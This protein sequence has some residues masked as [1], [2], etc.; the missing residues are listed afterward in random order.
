MTFEDFRKWMAPDDVMREIGVITLVYAR[1][2]ELLTLVTTGL[3]CPRNEDK[4]RAEIAQKGVTAKLRLFKDA[5]QSYCNITEKD[6][7][8][9]HSVT[10]KAKLAIQ[11]RDDLVHGYPVYEV[12]DAHGTNGWLSK[13]P[14]VANSH[15]LT[16]GEVFLTAEQLFDAYMELNEVAGLVWTT[17]RKPG[18]DAKAGQS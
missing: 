12:D 18:E 17:R 3:E 2:E 8:Q 14:H 1:I 9:I 15:A 13:R 11:R 16:V 4:R 5:A 10:E 7:K 6:L